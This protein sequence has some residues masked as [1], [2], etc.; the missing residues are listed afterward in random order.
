MRP[1]PNDR[2]SCRPASVALPVAVSPLVAPTPHVE[3]VHLKQTPEVGMGGWERTPRRRRCYPDRRPEFRGQANRKWIGA[4]GVD[5]RSE[6]QREIHVRVQT[7][8][9]ARQRRPIERTD[10]MGLAVYKS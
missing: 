2:E 1:E 4:R 7:V 6:N 9:N 3:Q 8:D 5:L 10:R